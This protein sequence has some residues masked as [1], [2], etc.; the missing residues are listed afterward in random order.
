[1]KVVVD[2]NIVFSCIISRRYNFLLL[3]NSKIKIYAP[4]FIFE[5]I[6]KYND[7]LL[8]KSKFSHDDLE[9][10]LDYITRRIIIIN[11][12][13]LVAYSYEA[14]DISPDPKDE[15]Y[16]ALALKQ[17]IPIWSNDAE[18]KKQKKVKVYTTEE[19]IEELK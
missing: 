3:M 16:F 18:L 6:A 11:S 4:D 13:E 17:N 8:K 5:E 19:L 15:A 14:S 9:K 12:S 10:F 2:A 1:M 7:Y